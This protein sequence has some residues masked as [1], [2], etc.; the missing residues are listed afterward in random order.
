[1]K[2]SDEIR[3]SHPEVR[4]AV[5]A[6]FLSGCLALSLWSLC[7]LAFEICLSLPL[8]RVLSLPL[9]AVGGGF[10]YQYRRI[11]NLERQVNW[12]IQEQRK[13]ESSLAPF[14]YGKGEPGVTPPDGA[15]TTFI[16]E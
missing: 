16:K 12:L 7:N 13:Q 14:S 2:R 1:M 8:R 3:Y 9:S 15:C 6:A 10:A 4:F 11:Q 5:G